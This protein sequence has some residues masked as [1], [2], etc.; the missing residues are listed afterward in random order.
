MCRLAGCHSTLVTVRLGSPDGSSFRLQPEN[1][2]M[3]RMCIT[4][5]QWEA[6]SLFCACWLGHMKII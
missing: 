3:V 5:K 6:A 2:Q 1:K 4:N